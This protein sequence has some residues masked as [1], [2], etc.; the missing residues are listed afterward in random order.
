MVSKSAVAG[1]NVAIYLRQ[2]K[3]SFQICN[4][5]EFYEY[6][7]FWCSDCERALVFFQAHYVKKAI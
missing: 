6:N 4:S 2:K 1:F 3:F 7:L 5:K